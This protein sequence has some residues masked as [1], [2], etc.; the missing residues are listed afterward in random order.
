MS[1][2][3]RGD[4]GA[5]VVHLVDAVA[6]AACALGVRAIPLESARPICALHG[7]LGGEGSPISRSMASTSSFARRGAAFSVG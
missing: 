2:A 5:R 3:I 1:L 7:G 4:P 6:E